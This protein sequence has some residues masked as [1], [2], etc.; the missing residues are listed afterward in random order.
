MS[1]RHVERLRQLII[2]CH[3]DIRGLLWS[4]GNGTIFILTPD[5]PRLINRTTCRS[6]RVD[7]E[8]DR[9]VYASQPTLHEADEGYRIS[10]PSIMV[11]LVPL[12]TTGYGFPER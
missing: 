1:L 4:T 7:W 12:N 5:L 11:G 8:V 9:P 10:H 3:L 6:Q 2:C